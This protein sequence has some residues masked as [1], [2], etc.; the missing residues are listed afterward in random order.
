MTAEMIRNAT[1]RID[2]EI[3]ELV[4]GRGEGPPAVR[5]VGVVIDDVTGDGLDDGVAILEHDYPGATGRFS[6]LALFHQPDDTMQQTEP[7]V[8]VDR[9]RTHDVRVDATG[10]L[11]RWSER[12]FFEGDQATTTYVFADD[13]LA[14]ADTVVSAL[15]E[16]NEPGLRVDG[17]NALAFGQ[18]ID[19]ARDTL[20]PVLGEPTSV[21]STPT[22]W[23]QH[24]S[25]NWEA[26]ESYVYVSF[27]EGEFYQWGANDARFVTAEVV[28]P[29]A[30]RAW[31]EEWF[32]EPFTTW[33][34]ELSGGIFTD[35]LVRAMRLDAT[36]TEVDS[37]EGTWE[38][39]NARLHTV[40]VDPFSNPGLWCGD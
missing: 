7:I 2:G 38:S 15:V 39:E 4:E 35:Q 32:G 11:L 25:L 28:A 1:V 20:T 36:A 30:S 18:S 6:S 26:G 21:R 17:S 10:V 22:C 8:Y 37:I 34:S 19:V 29:G 24:D 23:G 33:T 27:L 13:Q 40:V 14:A 3:V 31:L 5:V 12:L 16:G 9:G